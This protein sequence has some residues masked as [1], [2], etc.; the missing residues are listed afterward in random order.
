MR[1]V[2]MLL[3]CLAVLGCAKSAS[4]T[5]PPAPLTSKAVETIRSNYENCALTMDYSKPERERLDEIVFCIS[6]GFIH[7]GYS[8]D[9]TMQDALANQKNSEWQRG[10]KNSKLDEIMFP[11]WYTI[12][13][14]KV[15]N[16]A[17]KE[18]IISAET[19][20]KL[21]VYK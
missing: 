1:S 15:M 8:L 7:S 19:L 4:L 13:E 11:I 14:E 10:Y 21:K 16:Y 3:F 12:N 18:D 5:N 17:L 9:K 2:L 20:E 6:E